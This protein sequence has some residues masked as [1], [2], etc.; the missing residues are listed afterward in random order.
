MYHIM[1]YGPGRAKPQ[2]QDHISI[3]IYLFSS[4]R[5]YIAVLYIAQLFRQSF[6]D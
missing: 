2:A 4:N 5:T 1:S 6:L 3:S